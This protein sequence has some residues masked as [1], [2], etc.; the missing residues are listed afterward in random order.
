MYKFF[1]SENCKSKNFLVELFS[2]LKKTLFLSDA[3]SHLQR[4]VE[5][6]FYN[7]EIKLIQN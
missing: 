7:F 2:Y 5:K 4:K 6:L 3:I 1:L